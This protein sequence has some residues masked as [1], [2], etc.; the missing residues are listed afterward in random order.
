MKRFSQT[1]SV[2]YFPAQ[3]FLFFTTLLSAECMTYFDCTF[4]DEKVLHSQSNQITTDNVGALRDVE[5]KTTHMITGKRIMST[6]A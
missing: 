4:H 1:N 5:T 6:Q 2:L 3:F